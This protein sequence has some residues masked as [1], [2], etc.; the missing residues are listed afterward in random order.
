VLD[1]IVSPVGCPISRLPVTLLTLVCRSLGLADL[2][3]M[4]R[5][6]RQLSAA[7][8]HPYQ[9]TVTF[10]VDPGG[11]GVVLSGPHVRF[12][13]T[14]HMRCALASPLLRHHRRMTLTA[15]DPLVSEQLLANLQL[16]TAPM[17][18]ALT[19]QMSMP[20]AAQHG[21]LSSMHSWSSLAYLRVLVLHMRGEVQALLES[22]PPRLELL[23]LSVPPRCPTYYRRM[24]FA[25]VPPA[26]LRHLLVRV[27][28]PHML[29]RVDAPQQAI[30]ADEEHRDGTTSLEEL[31][32]L[33]QLQQ[34]APQLDTL[35]WMLPV[36]A[37]MLMQELQQERGALRALRHTQDARHR[38]LKQAFSF[39]SELVPPSEDAEHAQGATLIPGRAMAV[40]MRHKHVVEGL[41]ADPSEPSLE[42]MELEI[43]ELESGEAG[44]PAAGVTAA[45]SEASLYLS[46]FNADGSVLGYIRRDGSRLAL[47]VS[48][49]PVL[50]AQ[51]PHR[52]APA[53]LTVF[54]GR[55][56]AEASRFT[57]R[58]TE[59]AE[60]RA[61]QQG[62]F[63]LELRQG[64]TQQQRRRADVGEDDMQQA[65]RRRA[66]RLQMHTELLRA[67]DDHTDQVGLPPSVRKVSC[68]LVHRLDG[69]SSYDL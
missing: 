38:A 5:C 67:V 18:H 21:L 58:W 48:S 31:R 29:V 63:A 34:R 16:P 12:S 43:D 14:E 68:L 62:A 10:S 30:A 49:G 1:P 26:T 42:Q 50:D 56:A 33:K 65:Q 37:Q 47:V 52:G 28:T 60:H 44:T 46:S 3:A 53:R 35:A 69:R 40:L 11:V 2:L 36:S 51:L 22:L 9:H 13:S 23:Q 20:H 39:V 55:W 25:V 17:L 32:R 57:G 6:S 24:V 45:A 15:P 4:L 59:L 64:D 41:A 27:D 19:L 66:Q 7:A 54:E 61:K 8:L